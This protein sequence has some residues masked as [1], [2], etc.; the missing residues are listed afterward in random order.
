VRAHASVAELAARVA[1]EGDVLVV[2]EDVDA[3]ELVRSSCDEPNVFYLVGWLAVLPLTDASVDEVVA[4]G[5]PSEETAAEV[6]RVL[7]AGGSVELEAG[8]ED[9]G[10]AALNVDEHEAERLF[11]DAGFAAV[12]V[13]ALEDR[14]SVAAR[15]P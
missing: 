5:A 1:P 6:F 7:R 15:K 9:Q 11:T 4:R 3:L 14:L 2:D 10:P 13:R 8:N 12:T